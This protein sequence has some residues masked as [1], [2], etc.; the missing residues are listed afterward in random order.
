MLDNCQTARE[1]W[2]GV[3]ELVDRWLDERK[4]LLVIFCSLSGIKSFADN[5]DEYGPKI[6]RL[7]QLLVDYVSA[8]H[9]EVY[10]KL[11]QEGKQFDDTDGLKKAA[12]L[13]QTIDGTTESLLDFNDKYQEVDDLSTLVNDLST[14]GETLAERF[15]AEDAMIDV[16]HTAHQQLLEPEI[17]K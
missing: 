2:G 10:E 9:F 6:R 7:C 8:G 1:R 17:T 13:Y 5:D 16:L 4:E 12:E 14:M 3:N 11:I 15:E